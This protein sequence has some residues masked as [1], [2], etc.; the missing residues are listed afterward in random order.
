MSSDNV[1]IAGDVEVTTANDGTVN[2]TEKMDLLTDLQNDIGKRVVF[3]AGHGD[4]DVVCTQK[5][6]NIAR[7]T[8]KLVRL[9]IACVERCMRENR[10]M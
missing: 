4:M 3:L 8:L 7:E 9:G 10:A 1:T 2:V 5:G 6:R